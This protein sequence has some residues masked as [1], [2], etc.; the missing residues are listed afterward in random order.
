MY[1]YC[2]ALYNIV[3]YRPSETSVQLMHMHAGTYF[4]LQMKYTLINH[5]YAL[6]KGT[7]RICAIEERIENVR[8]N[9]DKCIK[10]IF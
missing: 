9:H 8:V 6:L 2:F 4:T 7:I 10:I 3:T 5:H 1:K